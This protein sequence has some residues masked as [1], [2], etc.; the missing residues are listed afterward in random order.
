MSDSDSN[1]P[2]EDP[3]STLNRRPTDFVICRLPDDSE[4][5][6]TRSA[7]QNTPGAEVVSDLV[8]IEGFLLARP[9]KSTTGDGDPTD[10]VHCRLHDGSVITRT[11]ATCEA[12]P[13]ATVVSN[14]LAHE[15]F[16]LAQRAETVD[17]DGDEQATDFVLCRLPDQ[18]E[19]VTTRATCEA[20]P[21]AVIVSDLSALGGFL[22]A[23]PIKSACESGQPT[24]LVICR[25]PSGVVI[26]TTRLACESI[27]EGVVVRDAGCP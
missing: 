7:C 12:T 20:A 11:R 2:Q 15:D 3:T 27:P 24:D 26:T 1:I 18:S 16:F 21:G 10:L 13:G 9:A 6:T 22:Q 23:Q 8:A 17:A 5:T 14:L 25:L 4:V 19:I